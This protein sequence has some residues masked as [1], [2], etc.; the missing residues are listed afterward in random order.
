[1]G[2]DFSRGDAHW[3]YSGFREFRKNLA[4]AI[5]YDYDKLCYTQEGPEGEALTPLL[6]HSDCEGKLTWEECAIVAPRLREVIAPW[7]S[8]DG[9]F[10]VKEDCSSYD[11]AHGSMLAEAMEACAR[12][13]CDL[14]FT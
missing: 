6:H 4:K 9:S 3:S 13:K 11:Y 7:K 10:Y 8:P 5:G 1:M 2:L 12:E 14:E